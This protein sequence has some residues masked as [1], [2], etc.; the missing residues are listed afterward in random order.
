MIIS[1]LGLLYAILMIQLVNLRAY[2]ALG[3]SSLYMRLQIIKV[4]GGGAIIWITA[5]I[6]H[7]HRRKIHF[8]PVRDGCG[9]QFFGAG[10]G[11]NR[12]ILHC[13]CALTYPG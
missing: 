1:I 7:R 9:S 10:F 11:D 4:L 8:L 6:T 13:H 3:D 12:F 2:M 5:A